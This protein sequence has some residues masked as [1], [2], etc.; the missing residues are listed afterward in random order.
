MVASSSGFAALE[1]KLSAASTA[2]RPQNERV[3]NVPQNTSAAS[4]SEARSSAR[5]AP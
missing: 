1:K 3:A 4:A 5:L 2:N